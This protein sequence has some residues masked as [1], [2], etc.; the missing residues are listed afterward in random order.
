MNYYKNY[1]VELDKEGEEIK[2]RKNWNNKFFSVTHFLILGVVVL[3]FIIYVLFLITKNL[4]LI[5]SFYYITGFLISIFIFLGA[6]LVSTKLLTSYFLF[7]IYLKKYKKFEK[8]NI[9]TAIIIAN[10]DFFNLK[11][12]LLAPFE[13]NFVDICEIC[14]FKSWNFKIYT[15]LNEEQFDEI[16]YNN[17]I[18]RLYLVGHG[19][20]NSFCLHRNKPV[21]YEKYRKDNLNQKLLKKYNQNEINKEFIAQYHCNH[22]YGNSLADYIV[23]D[24]EKRK[25]YDVTWKSHNVYLLNCHISKILKEE[26]KKNYKII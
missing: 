14:S 22:L 17:K 23:K 11:D 20:R 7:K 3:I 1:I 6:I 5:T 13:I 10:F 4:I 15:N 21:F 8:N 18:K 26:Q 9:D 25:Q 2:N 24:P 16:I 12:W 19:S